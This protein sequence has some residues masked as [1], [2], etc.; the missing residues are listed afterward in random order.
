MLGYGHDESA[1]TPDGV[2]APHFVGV[3]ECFAECSPRN[4]QP[5]AAVGADL[6]R[7]HI[8]KHPRNGGRK[9]V[10]DEMNARV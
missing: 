4:W 2:F 7:P 8:C 6:S 5:S 9:C 10:F 3:V 1:P